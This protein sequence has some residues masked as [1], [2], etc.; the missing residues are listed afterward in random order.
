MDIEGVNVPK[1]GE[2][3]PSTLDYLMHSTPPAGR[4]PVASIMQLATVSGEVVLIDLFA[5]RLALGGRGH[6][7][8]ATFTPGGGMG[9]HLPYGGRM[10]GAGRAD[11][12]RG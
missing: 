10:L 1:E 7:K 2:K 9:R 11:Q 3:I 4:G 5:F 8:T 12:G 6:G